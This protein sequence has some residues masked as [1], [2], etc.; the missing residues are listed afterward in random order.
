MKNTIL[1]NCW[2]ITLLT[3]NRASLLVTILY[4]Y[5]LSITAFSWIFGLGICACARSL[6]PS[7]A[8]CRRTCWPPIPRRPHSIH[9][10][11]IIRE[12]F[13]LNGFR[14]FQK[15]TISNSM[16]Y[17]EYL[18]TN[19]RTVLLVAIFGFPTLSV[20]VSFGMFWSCFHTVA[21]SSTLSSITRLWTCRPSTPSRPY[22]V[23]I[24]PI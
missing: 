4:I 16:H 8:T 6:L 19:D 9:T 23:R 12:M 14:P 15:W 18:Y 2:I 17:I 20:T 13:E 1:F 22:S 3:M 21:I 5:L 7:S 11:P 24:Y 10:C